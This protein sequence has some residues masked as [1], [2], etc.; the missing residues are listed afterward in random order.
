MHTMQNSKRPKIRQ[1]F[2]GLFLVTITRNGDSLI[3]RQ[4]Q[5]SQD[6]C[7]EWPLCGYYAAAAIMRPCATSANINVPE[8]SFSLFHWGCIKS[9]FT[10]PVVESTYLGLII[11]WMCQ[12]VW[13][14]DLQQLSPQTCTWQK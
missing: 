8:C 4:M 6:L 5:S 12:S 1:T 7:F 2:G 3:N 10:L 11:R 13:Q 9:T 14:K